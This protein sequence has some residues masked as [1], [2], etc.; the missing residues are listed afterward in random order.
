MEHMR[1]NNIFSKQQ[2]GFIKGRL[3]VLQLLNVMD[4]GTRQWVL[5]RFDIS[6]LYEGF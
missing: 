3:T 4:Y 2:F 5:Y 1:V 6:G